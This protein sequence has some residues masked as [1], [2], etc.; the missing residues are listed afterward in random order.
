MGY[1]GGI[2]RTDLDGSADVDG[3]SL[4]EDEIANSGAPVVVDAELDPGDPPE[5]RR[6]V[7]SNA[8]QPLRYQRRHP[9]VQHLERLRSIPVP[10]PIHRLVNLVATI[11]I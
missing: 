6:H 3:G 9:A 8:R 4:A 1:D 11:K 5:P 2:G 7:R 10:N